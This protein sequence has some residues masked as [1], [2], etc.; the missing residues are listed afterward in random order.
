MGFAQKEYDQE[1]SLTKVS[2]N[3]FSGWGLEFM[4]KR[5][6]LDSHIYQRLK[7]HPNNIKGK[8]VQR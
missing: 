4:N 3:D 6:F 8:R 5:W 1:V 2:S 7:M